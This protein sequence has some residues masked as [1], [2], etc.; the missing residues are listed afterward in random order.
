[1]SMAHCVAHCLVY[2]VCYSIDWDYTSYCDNC[3]CNLLFDNGDCD[4]NG[5]SDDTVIVGDGVTEEMVFLQSHHIPL[6]SLHKQHCAVTLTPL[7]VSKIQRCVKPLKK[8]V[9]VL[10][11]HPS[12]VSIQSVLLSKLLLYRHVLSADGP[13]WQYSVWGKIH[14]NVLHNHS[15]T[16]ATRSTFKWSHKPSS[17]RFG[18]YQQALLVL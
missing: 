6:L 16:K 4:C 3:T 2:F 10:F 14:C 17:A 11:P 12:S 13:S 7:C 5:V 15:L 9:H 18:P 1:M 8:A